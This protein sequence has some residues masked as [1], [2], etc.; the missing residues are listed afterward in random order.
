MYN[1]LDIHINIWVIL[2]FGALVYGHV[3]PN[4]HLYIFLDATHFLGVCS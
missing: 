2:K 4:T 3:C 1:C